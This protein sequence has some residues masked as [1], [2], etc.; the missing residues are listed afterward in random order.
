MS[1]F[2]ISKI[3]E[4]LRDLENKTANPDFW[5][6][7]KNSKIV[8][9]KIKNLKNKRDA[10]KKIETKLSATIEINS[11]LQT[12]ADDNLVAE[13][14]E[15]TKKIEKEIERLE[16]TTYLSGKYDENNAIITLHPGARWY[17]ISGLG[18]N[19]I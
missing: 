7:T 1:L 2:D 6:D 17:R 3:D 8:L 15:D 4:E 10:F 18:R 11:L 19:A 5:N 14:I 16:I 12:E 13:V 9:Q